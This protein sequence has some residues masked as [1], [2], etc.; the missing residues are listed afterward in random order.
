MT[1]PDQLYQQ[2]IVDHSKRPR[3]FGPLAGKSHNGWKENPMCGDRIGVELALRGTRIV[4]IRF[5]GVGC[6]IAKASASMMTERAQGTELHELETLYERFEQLLAGNAADRSQI[7]ELFAFEHVAKFP[8]R[9]RCAKLPWQ[10]LW[11]ALADENSP[12]A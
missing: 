9:I 10:A 11:R 8:V 12:T 6:A 7:G 5:Q 1:S 4:A 2:L 3:N